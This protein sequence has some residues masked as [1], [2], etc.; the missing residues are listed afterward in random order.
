M[1]FTV[2]VMV[3]L[4]KIS[5]E[6]TLPQK[7]AKIFQYKNNVLFTSLIGHVVVII[8]N[9]S[10]VNH[11]TVYLVISLTY[12]LIYNFFPPYFFFFL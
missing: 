6:E 1:K 12:S 8:I 11:F 2:K 5:V 3:E 9:I 10:I 4:G 7:I